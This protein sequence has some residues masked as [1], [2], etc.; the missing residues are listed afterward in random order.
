MIESKFSVVRVTT[1]LARTYV[2]SKAMAVSGKSE[3]M[4]KVLMMGK[5]WVSRSSLEKGRTG[6]GD[7]IGMG[8]Q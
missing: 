8:R 1:L 7:I 3:R 6:D 4:L 2:A 5:S